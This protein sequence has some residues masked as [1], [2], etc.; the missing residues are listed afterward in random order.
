MQ[1]TTVQ[2]L[3][4]MLAETGAAGPDGTALPASILAAV[5]DDYVPPESE[6]EA[7]VVTVLEAPASSTRSGR[8]P[9]AAPRRRAGRVDFI[10]RAAPLVIEADSRR[11]HWS[12]L[13]VEADHRRIC[14]SWPPATDRP[15]ELASAHQEPELFLAAVRSFLRRAAA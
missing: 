2:A 1:L 4:L 13:D 11:Y 5:V 12:W 15:G 6:L 10:F 3:G 8:R 9:S 7:L 14:C